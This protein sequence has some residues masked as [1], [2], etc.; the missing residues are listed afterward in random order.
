MVPETMAQFDLLY[1]RS[2]IKHMSQPLLC[3]HDLFRL[4]RQILCYERKYIIIACPT[5]FIEKRNSFFKKKW[6]KIKAFFRI[7]GSGFLNQFGSTKRGITKW[8]PTVCSNLLSLVLW[9]Q[10]GCIIRN[11]QLKI[12]TLFGEFRACGYFA[13]GQQHNLKLLLEFSSSFRCFWNDTK[14]S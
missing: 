4:Y 8:N 6:L 3:W 10:I 14:L 12:R 13:P 11:Q 7:N 9:R 5:I 2:I 1:Y